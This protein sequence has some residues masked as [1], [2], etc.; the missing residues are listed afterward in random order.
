MMSYK[1]SKK[2][3]TSYYLRIQHK[4]KQAHPSL[5]GSDLREVSQ[6][7]TYPSPPATNAPFVLSP[8]I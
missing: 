7:T 5:V 2:D 8:A 6:S 4:L 3:L 1:H